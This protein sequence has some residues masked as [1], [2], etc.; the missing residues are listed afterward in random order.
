VICPLARDALRWHAIHGIAERAGG[1]A[2]DEREDRFRGG[3]IGVDP[4]FLAEPEHG[5]QIVG[6]HARVCTDRAV[7]V[8]RDALAAVRFDRAI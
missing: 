4:R 6:A 5:G 8:N 3:G 1:T 2:I 7:I